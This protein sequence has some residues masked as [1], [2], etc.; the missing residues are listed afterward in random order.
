MLPGF[1]LYTASEQRRVDTL[2]VQA[3]AQQL[4]QLAA[5]N[6]EELVEGTR[7][8]LFTFAQLPQ[9]RNPATCNTF[10][11]KLLKQYPLYTN[12]GTPGSSGFCGC[13]RW[14]V[15]CPSWEAI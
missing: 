7:Q 6:Q 9:V 2:E 10:F 14:A 3:N 13:C 8:L 1:V 4:T 12:F 11:A 15:W 5:R